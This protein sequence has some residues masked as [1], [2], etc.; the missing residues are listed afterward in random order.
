MAGSQC[1]RASNDYTD[2]VLTARIEALKL[3]AERSAERVAVLGPGLEVIYANKSAWG[4]PARASALPRHA[5]CYEAFMNQS[6]PCGYCP[7]QAVFESQEVYSV[8]CS[9]GV[10]ATACGMH[11]A[12][13]L[14]SS[15][16]DTRSVL[17]LFK[18]EWSG[19]GAHMAEDPVSADK[20][21][22]SEPVQLGEL[23]GRSDPMRRLCEMIRM[24]ADSPATVLV[25]G[26]SGTGKE[27]VARTIHRTSYRRDK[28][29]VVVDCGALPETLLESELFGHVKGAFT[30]A[31]A[32][33]KGLFEEADG[34]TI[35]L[36]EIADTTPHFQAKL[37]RVLQEGEMKAVGSSRGIKVD[38]RVIS[39]SNK[40]L[41]QLV[42]AG[43]FRQDLFYRLA[44]LPLYL[45][46]LRERR[47]DIPLLVEHFVA[48][49]CARHRQPV[50]TVS[51]DALHALSEADWPGNVRELQHYIERA[52]VTT[53]GSEIGC[54]DIV[55]LG[56]SAQATDLW[57]VTRDAVHQAERAR[58]IQALRQTGGNRVRAAKLLK[59]S[60]AS[61]YNKLRSYTIEDDN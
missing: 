43:R 54:K 51:T 41:E 39:A 56:T 40:D 12:H 5:K 23:I 14:R 61:L 49:S 9:A 47:E 16:G 35:F 50:R 36:D 22:E 31:V 58:I 11:Q 57:S 21:E 38:V 45:P 37:L 30:G 24:V 29:F 60:R 59:I 15:C 13:A 1:D 17:V 48:V 2:P 33:K 52:V 7:A 42:K 53:T 46:P 44:V 25:Q 18:Q 6:D 4:D 3:L 27:L 10:D 26:E 28:P 55:A 20:V 8:S 32:H 19:A 34:G